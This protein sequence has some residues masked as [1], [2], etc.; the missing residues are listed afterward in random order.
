[1]ES[2]LSLKT[3]KTKRKF[4]VC[5]LYTNK[6]TIHSQLRPFNY[7]RVVTREEASR[8]IGN[9]VKQVLKKDP[10]RKSTDPIC[11]FKDL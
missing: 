5:R 4:I 7:D 9:F 11:R 6:Q 8:M 2:F 3:E 10:M 1:M